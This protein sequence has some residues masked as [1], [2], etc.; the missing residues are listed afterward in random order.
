MT[1]SIVEDWQSLGAWTPGATIA[2]HGGLTGQAKYGQP[3]LQEIVS[4]TVGQK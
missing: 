2:E 3:C 1:R 4:G